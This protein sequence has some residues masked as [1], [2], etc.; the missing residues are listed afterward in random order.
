MKNTEFF[1]GEKSIYFEVF[2]GLTRDFKSYV[3]SFGVD[4]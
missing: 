2:F 3:I 4:I 1:L